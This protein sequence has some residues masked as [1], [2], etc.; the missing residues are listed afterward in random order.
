MK[1][2][3]EVKGEVEKRT[4]RNTKE[5][6]DAIAE[7]LIKDFDCDLVLEVQEFKGERKFKHINPKWLEE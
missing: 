1:E 2:T 7:K 3:E 6:T 5:E 4:H